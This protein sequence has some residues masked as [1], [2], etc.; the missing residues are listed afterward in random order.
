[1]EMD[2]SM[3][4][5]VFV[6]TGCLLASGAMAQERQSVPF[7][8]SY[9]QTQVGQSV[10]VVGS[11]PELGGND[12]TKAV[13]LEPSQW[14]LW[15]G[16]ISLPAGRA[17]TYQLLRR[18]DGPG[19]LG[20][21]AGTITIGPVVSATTDAPSPEPSPA[22]KAVVY[23]SGINPPTIHWRAAGSGAA[24]SSR[25]MTAIGPGRS[26]GES[27]W[28]AWDLQGDGGRPRRTIEFYFT[29]PS[30]Q[31]DPVVG[32]NYTT[33]LDALLV[34]DANVY[35]YVPAAAPGVARRDY[36]PASPPFINSTN[37]G[38]EQRRYRVFL[39]RGYD[40]HTTLRYPVLYMHDGQNVF[41]SGPFGTWD[42][43]DT[44][45]R[46]MRQGLMREVIIVGVDNTSNRLTNYAAPDSGGQAD[47][48]VRFIRDEL[49]PLI[50]AQYR[51]RPGPDDTGAVG[52]SMGGQVSLY[53]GWD[54]PE[55]FRRIGAMSGA[56]SVFTS[57]F[58][59]RVF[60]QAKRPIRIYL[61]SGDAGTANDGYWSTFNLRDA[62][63]RKS[64]GY[65]LEEDLRHRIGIG[66]QH[67]E[68]AWAARL[69]ECFNFLFPAVEDDNPLLA[70]ASG[71]SADVNDDGE[72]DV[73]DLYEQVA[74]GR[75]VNLDGSADVAD[76]GAMIAYLRR[77][78]AAIR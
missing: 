29:G 11:L 1:M 8:V 18:N 67:N 70:L 25:A 59:D 64:P 77:N 48:Y 22:A 13:K 27:R 50:D 2:L 60:A 71:A 73:D 49:K 47:R 56:W 43:D 78:E 5:S 37:L 51:T 57:G 26:A 75:D 10:F 16:T 76:I 55:T 40:Q 69:P 46:L 17:Y 38:G 7:S 65:A 12:M 19:T 54:Y 14:P 4:F 32:N 6:I 31:R 20:S 61:D 3:K 44:G 74:L 45:P 33:P 62:L 68:A 63:M 58:Y 35:S 39:P 66:Q 41:E 42:A 36:N 30:G 21:T 15:R 52:S 72:A 9:N 53:M 23:L 24:F 28:I 34:Q